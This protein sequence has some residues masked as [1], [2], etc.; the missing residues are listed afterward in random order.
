[1]N[2]LITRS[3]LIWA[4]FLL[5][6]APGVAQETGDNNPPSIDLPLFT[7]FD[8]DGNEVSLESY[9]GKVVMLNFWATWC[10]PCVEE[11]PTMRAL[12]ESLSDKPFEILAVNMGETKEAI[13]QF[14]EKI[15]IEFNFPLLLDPTTSVATDY[16]VSGLPATLL[17]DKQGQFSFGGVGPR[18]WNDDDARNQILPLLN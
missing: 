17:I 3:W 9:R 7:L 14:I 12:K 11:L 2:K 10:A 15:G 1:M 16:S 8:I 4:L 6:S 18:D 13:K 5:L